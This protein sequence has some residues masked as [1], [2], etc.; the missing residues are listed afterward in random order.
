MYKTE[1]QARD[2]VK[3]LKD[4]GFPDNSI[5]LVTP[6][7]SGEAIL[8]FTLGGDAEVY[9]Q[10]MARGRSIVLVRAAFGLGQA[11]ISI[12]ESGDPVDTDLLAPPK[13]ASAWEE[14]GAPFS[15]AMQW[16][17]L[18]RNEPAPFS[19][20]LGIPLITGDLG[21]ESSMIGTLSASSPEL[22]FGYRVLS[23]KATPLSSLLGLSVLSDKGPGE[24]SFGLP[25]QLVDKAPL[26]SFFGLPL[27]TNQL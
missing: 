9:A 25:L 18:K 11:V 7:A 2:V 14:S 15:S 22:S 1:Q 21:C 27:L 16:P 5:L 4:D 19:D 13:V 12:M 8:G 10:S 6:G 26:S 3:K 17:V 23:D 20:F 24:E